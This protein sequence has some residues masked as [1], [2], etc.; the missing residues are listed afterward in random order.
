MKSPILIAMLLLL[1][2][3]SLPGQVTRLDGSTAAAE[4]LTDSIQSLVTAAEVTG[5]TVSI[6]N[7]NE[8][9]YQQAF[10]YADREHRDTLQTNHV[11]YGAS[12]SKAIFGYIA[13]RLHQEGHFDLDRPLQSYLDTLLP[14]IPFEKEWRGYADLAADEDER[15]RLVTGRMCLSHTSGLPNWRWITQDWELN[16]KE[17]LRFF[18]DPGE[19]YNYSGEGIALLQFVIERHTGRS[20]EAWAEAYVFTPF[21]MPLSSYTWRERFEDRY[22]LGH[23]A[24]QNP[25]PKD[26]RNAPGAAGSLETTP[27]DYARFVRGLLRAHAAG[28]PVTKMMWSPQV[29]IRSRR[30]FGPGAW[31][32]TAENDAVE[33]SYG[34]GWGLLATPHGPAAFKEGHSEGFQHYSIVFPEQRTGVILMSNSDNA[35]SIFKYLLELTIGDTFTPWRWEGFD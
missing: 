28:S 6:L 7:D 4:R 17:P 2:Q 27:R 26:K 31:E 15:Y 24:E 25:L 14:D 11:F 8:I 19:R 3:L 12:F 13:T 16:G 34:L 30:Q 9:V 18:F 32:T 33:L 21:A 10:G 23:T 22:C 29:R 20:L 5:L 1:P 35:E